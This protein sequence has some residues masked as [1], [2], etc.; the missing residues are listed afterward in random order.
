M[1][2]LG[3]IAA[4]LIGITLGLIGAGGSILT[5]PVLV[6][7][8]RVSPVLATSYS[9]FIVG[10]TALFGSLGYMKNNL[11]NYRTAIVF[12]IPSL[13]GVFAARHFLLPSIPEDLFFWG[14]ILVTKG[15]G[16]MILFAVLMIAASVSMI[17]KSKVI[18]KE[19]FAPVQK[20]RYGLILLEGL[21][22]GGLTGLVGAGGGFLIIPALVILAGEPMKIAIGTSLLIISSKSLIGFSGDLM[23]HM[24]INWDFL[25]LFSAFAVAGI[26]IGAWLSSRIPGTGSKLKPVF[27]WFVLVM[28]IFIL[29]QE[30][31]YS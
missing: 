6:Y 26:L 5:V 21:I 20:Y 17:K 16:I 24:Q 14:N 18:H 15:I 1:E 3:F 25:L 7:L 11:V 30:I 12:G 19:E 10:I 29:A 8:L 13:I 22:V 9:L 31:F 4:V 28:G 27:G 23:N 2:V